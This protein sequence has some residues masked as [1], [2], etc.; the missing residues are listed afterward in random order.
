VTNEEIEEEEEE[1]EEEESDE[2]EPAA[3][4][5]REKGKTLNEHE[6]RVPGLDEDFKPTSRNSQFA[7]V[8]GEGDNT[9]TD[10]RDMEKGKKRKKK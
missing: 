4:I 9:S 6:I 8:Q 7:L 10:T 5:G 2:I 1:E 3:V